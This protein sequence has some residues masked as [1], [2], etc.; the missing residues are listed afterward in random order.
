MNM[1]DQIVACFLCAPNLTDFFLYTDYT[2]LKS[3]AIMARE[4]RKEPTF[5]FC[6]YF[7][8][9]AGISVCQCLLFYHLVVKI[10]MILIQK[11]FDH[12]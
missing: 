3:L 4:G 12:S 8:C 6:K 11:S 7:G 2:Q 9:D 1:I 5:M 10:R